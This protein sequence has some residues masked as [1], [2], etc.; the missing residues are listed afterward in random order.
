MAYIRNA[1]YVAMWSQDLNSQPQNRLILNEPIVLFRDGRGNIAA[2]DDRCPH[3]QAPLHLGKVCESGTLQCGYHGLEFD[4]SGACVRNPHGNGSIPKAMRVKS[5]PV[6]EMHSLVWIWMGE[7]EPDYS[8]I[9]DLSM[10]DN[11][12]PEHVTRRDFLSMNANYEL[13]VNNLLDLSHVAFLHK[14]VL[15][16]E[17]STGAQVKVTQEGDNVTVSRWMPGVAAP[18]LF[19][20]LFQRDGRDVDMWAEI[21]W[22][23]PGSLLNDTGVTGIGASREAGSGIIGLH[24]LTPETEQSTLYHFAAVRTN[25]RSFPPDI[26]TQIM[27]DLSDLRRKAFVEEDMPMIEAQQRMLGLG[28]GEREPVL[29]EVD[30]GAARMRRILQQRIKSETASGISA[31]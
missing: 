21:T 20:M 2:L 12:L 29:L 8:A 7:R 27:R 15:G 26:E 4:K 18:R 24:L 9:P 19:D 10:L 6:K 23:P 28:N 11:A 13:V 14:G 30:G 1:W 31:P 3:R 5:Y 17:D 22:I 16:N 25:P